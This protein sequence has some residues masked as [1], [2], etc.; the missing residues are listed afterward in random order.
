M[1]IVVYTGYKKPFFP[2]FT[3]KKRHRQKCHQS[4]QITKPSNRNNKP[5]QRKK[6]IFQAV[7]S[8]YILLF[9]LS[10]HSL[11]ISAFRHL[12]ERSILTIHGFLYHRHIRV[13]LIAKRSYF[14]LYV[15]IRCFYPFPLFRF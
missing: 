15:L 7:V 9:S 11:Y 10:C 8:L 6:P 12:V 5:M 1:H 13:H 3:H 2:L 14:A 4:P